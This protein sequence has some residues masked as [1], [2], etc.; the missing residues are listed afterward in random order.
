MQWYRKDDIIVR[1]VLPSCTG[2]SGQSWVA[3]SGPGG[4]LVKSG[5][6]L[7]SFSSEEN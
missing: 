4:V 3:V 2:A 1:L 5:V 6:V 7:S